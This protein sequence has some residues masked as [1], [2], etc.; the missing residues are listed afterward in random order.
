VRIAMV[1]PYSISRPGGVQGQVHG[2]ARSLDRLG[3]DVVV[4]CPSDDDPIGPVAA[5][6][7]GGEYIVGHATS[8]RSNG[9]VVPLALSPM[10]AVR[11]RR[12]IAE[13]SFDVAHLHEPM[14]PSVGYACLLTHP[15]P[16]V[17]TFHRAGDSWWYRLLRPVAGWAS[18][19]LDVRCAVSEAAR[20]TAESAMGGRYQLLFNGVEVERFATA[21]PVT[22]DRPTV[23]FLG[24]HEQRK[25]LGVLLDA[26]DRVGGDA[27]LWVVGSGPDTAGLSREHP[28]SDRLHWLGMLD[29][30]EVASR[31]AGA[32]V[33]CAPSLRGESF[34]MVLL[35]A[36]AARCAVVASDLP[37][38]RDASGG[39]AALV[40]P[41]DPVAL[42]A[43]L[44]TAVA[45]AAAGTGRSSPGA[46]S[47]AVG[48]AEGWSM[49][50]LARR[51]VELY[52]DAASMGARRRQV[53]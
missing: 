25:G 52:G 17:G 48:H 13:G 29:D 33:L 34:G 36:M 42:A 30:D 12:L 45:D 35:E 14:A 20:R 51:Y 9:S 23:L 15:L 40:A 26:F 1:C 7:G 32:Q 47:A 28:G 3:H 2:L 19:R 11:T 41:G 39:H 38:Y 22:T 46:L 50:R 53:A 31:L 21:T 8:L 44:S 5:A 43:A 18:R 6:G 4:L 16:L 49:D 24:R 10:A 27:V 37:G